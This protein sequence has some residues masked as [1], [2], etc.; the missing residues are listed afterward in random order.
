M[1][2]PSP[3]DAARRDREL[4]DAIAAGYA[5]KDLH[6]ASRIARRHRLLR[7]VARVPLAPD[8]RILEVGCGAGFAAHYLAGRYAAYHGIDH[9]AALIDH[10][11]TRFGAPAVRFDVADVDGFE[12]DGPYDLVLMIGVL[13]HLAAPEGTLRRLRGRLRPGGFLAANEPQSGNPLLQAARGIRTRI[14]P[15]YS[16]DQRTFGA[17]AL[18]RMLVDSGF[19]RVD[20]RPQGFL[21]TPFAEVPLGP[22][23]WTR[24]LAA[25]ACRIDAAT[26]DALGPWLEPLSWNLVATGR[27]PD[28]D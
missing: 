27:R 14:D 7:T 16:A 5:R 11:R 26:E 8:A 9:A 10:A 24:R 6:P 12:T 17:A 4:F 13:H 2:G 28:G 23:A 25:A 22:A 20:V 1:T 18:F 15:A 21:S 3:A 19:D